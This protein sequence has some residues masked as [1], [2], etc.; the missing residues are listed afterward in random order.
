MSM[1]N[2]T[3]IDY[4]PRETGLRRDRKFR[5]VKMKYGCVAVDVYEI[6][7]DLIYSD[8][9]YYIQ[10]DEDSK[11]DVQWDIAQDLQGK[12][13]PE[14]DTIG[15][16]IDDLVKAGLFSEEYY[17]KGILTSRRIQSVYYK[18]TIER[19]TI[20]VDFNI[21]LLTEQEMTELSTRSAI[22]AEFQNRSDSSQNQ[23]DKTQNQPILRQSKVK[24]SKVNKIKVNN[25][26]ENNSKEKPPAEQSKA[27]AVA[28]D[29]ELND[30]FGYYEKNIGKVTPYIADQLREY[31]SRGAE[32]ALIH[33]LIDYSVGENTAKWS[34]LNGC[35]TGCLR[36]GVRTAEEYDRCQAKRAERRAEADFGRSASGIEPSKFNNYT[37]TNKIDYAALEEKLLEQMLM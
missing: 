11:L 12:D 30:L 32:P 25:S 5:T 34:Y 26:K 24:E 33:R 15:N 20:K 10:Y 13:C 18:A 6:L 27:A 31:I 23:S 35:I 4:Y 29:N 21:W 22:L 16:I 8:K 19:K 28:V 17:K 37:D 36:D 1:P 7:L 3:S 14:F 9:G 2:K